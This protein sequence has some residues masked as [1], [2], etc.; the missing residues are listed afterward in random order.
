M[1]AGRLALCLPSNAGSLELAAPRVSAQPRS[2]LSTNG[3]IMFS[4]ILGVA[5]AACFG[6]FERLSGR[7]W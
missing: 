6:L 1:Y 5:A 4:P 2:N 7:V 3:L